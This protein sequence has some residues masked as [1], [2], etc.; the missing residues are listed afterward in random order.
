MVHSNKAKK[1]LKQYLKNKLPTEMI[2]YILSFENEIQHLLPM[3]YHLKH[4]EFMFVPGESRWIGIDYLCGVKFMTFY[5]I[6]RKNKPDLSFDERKQE[7]RGLDV[8]EKAM[9]ISITRNHRY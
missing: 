4:T 2:N 1:C 9:W 7:Y 6:V 5:S 3:K 8:G